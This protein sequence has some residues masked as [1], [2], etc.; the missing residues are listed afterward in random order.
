MGWEVGG[1]W[2]AWVGKDR[3]VP[4]ERDVSGEDEGDGEKGM[5]M[6]NGI[7]VGITC[8]LHGILIC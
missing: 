3:E 6:Q 1:M 5:N 7:L 8:F 4:M 2:K